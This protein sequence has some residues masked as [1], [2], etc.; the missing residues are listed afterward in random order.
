MT[1]QATVTC[2]SDFRTIRRVAPDD[3]SAAMS[4][5]DSGSGQPRTI[6]FEP[7]AF[8]YV[9]GRWIALGEADED[10]FGSTTRHRVLE[11]CFLSAGRQVGY[12]RFDEYRPAAF[13]SDAEF[14][15]DCDGYSFDASRFA[16]A[17]LSGWPASVAETGML[18]EFTRLWMEPGHA[19]SNEWATPIGRLIRE[20]WAGNRASRASLLLLK[21]WPLEMEAN[22]HMAPVLHEAR[23]A[24]RSQAMRR[25][26]ARLLGVRPLH[27]GEWMWRT[28]SGRARAPSR[29]ERKWARFA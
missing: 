27:D 8:S 15:D 3:V 6:W 22:A 29:K 24:R 16:Q 17:L 12:A 19:R 14:W 25:L 11:G 21:P 26:Y 7:V 18:V 13:A 23:L 1:A 4:A 28:F 10:G 20:R 5:L 2:V 9:V